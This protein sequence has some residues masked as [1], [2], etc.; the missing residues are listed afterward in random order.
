MATAEMPPPSATETLPSAPME[1]IQ[2]KLHSRQGRFSPAP[3]TEGRPKQKL[4]IDP[5]RALEPARK[6]LSMLE[7]Q[8]VMAVLVDAIKR[9]EIVTALPYIV[10]NIDRFG[11]SFGK[12]L[13]R[14][15]EDHKMIIESFEDIKEE[16]G[17]LFERQK[18]KEEEDS[19]DE[20]NSA[21]DLSSHSSDV[22]ATAQLEN[23][24]KQL[25][26][27]ART[28]QASCKDILRAFALNPTA[29]TLVLKECRERSPNA[30]AYIAYLN[31]LKDILMHKLLTTPV[32]EA[33]R[34]DFIHEIMEREK[35]NA[36]VIAK[37]EVDL[38]AAIGDKEAEVRLRT[39]HASS[40]HGIHSCMFVFAC[41]RS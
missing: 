19:L 7:A 41:F 13:V 38:Q 6:K 17:K 2:M 12:E 23:A 21:S 40:A 14:K 31:E 8:R 1:T 28:M 3:P 29:M 26:I 15:L 30:D 16:A 33:E 35:H 11:V 4:K 20:D 25:Q 22:R 39:S 27:L 36:S 32:E 24:M 37:L 34:N 5:L 9:T 18:R 10:E